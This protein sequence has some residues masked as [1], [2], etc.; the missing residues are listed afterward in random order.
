MRPT[1]T[2]PST[3]PSPVGAVQRM[4]QRAG[5]ALVDLRRLARSPRPAARRRPAPASSPSSRP[6]DTRSVSVPSAIRAAARPPA[7]P[8]PSIAVST[9]M[10]SSASRSRFEATASPSR[11]IERSTR[12]RS[13]RSSSSR[14]SSW[15]AIV[16]NSAPSSANS[17][18]PTVGT[19]VS[20]SPPPSRRAA[21]R[22]DATC[23]CSERETASA[24]AKASRKNPSRT[25][26]TISRLSVTSPSVSASSRSS[27]T[28]QQPVAEV[29]PLDR[30]A[31]VLVCRRSS[32]SRCPAGSVHASRR[33]GSGAGQ[34]A[35]AAAHDDV[36]LG[37]VLDQP[38]R[39]ASA[40]L[41]RDLQR[42]DLR[43]VGQQRAARPGT[44]RRRGRRWRSCG[45]RCR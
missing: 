26:P 42:A 30:R 31:A 45:G 38:A 13:S 28:S 25:P 8:T 1:E 40:D 17:S 29:A 23:D 39:T 22:N 2:T 19:L 12:V 24:K 18:L 33:P 14:R 32:P 9:T 4:G 11:R 7:A 3:S 21:S 41:D 35:A 34:R 27:V 44:S 5:R 16:L 15:A 20:N 10:P 43:A 37:D 6:A 36:E